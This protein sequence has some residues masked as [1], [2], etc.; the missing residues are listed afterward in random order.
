LEGYFWYPIGIKLGSFQLR[1]ASSGEEGTAGESI[2]EA[3]EVEVVHILC[4]ILI[5]S[6]YCILAWEGQK[7]MKWPIYCFFYFDNDY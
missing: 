6:T 2:G 1:K 4:F 5:S 7:R 3:G